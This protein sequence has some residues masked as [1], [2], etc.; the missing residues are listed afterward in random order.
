MLGWPG[1]TLGE[2]PEL[3]SPTDADVSS[4]QGSTSGGILM[5]NP[6]SFAE[7]NLAFKLAVEAALHSELL[8]L[9]SD[10]GFLGTSGSPRSSQRCGLR[11]RPRED[12]HGLQ[13][14]NYLVL[15]SILPHTFCR[16]VSFCLA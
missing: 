7:E 9:L 14:P 12:P 4:A 6:L 8:M 10:L 13:A 3:S 15:I 16:H 5:R 2:Q 1:E 11:A